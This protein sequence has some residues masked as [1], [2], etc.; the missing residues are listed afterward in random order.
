[1]RERSDQGGQSQSW[2][3]ELVAEWWA[4]FNLGW[5]EIDYGRF[6]GQ[7]QPALDAGC[8][9]TGRPADRDLPEPWPETAEP[10]RVADGSELLLR[11]RAVNV[12]PLDQAIT[13]ERGRS[14]GTTERSSRRA[15]T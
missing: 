1:L 9:T 14:A 2:H 15:C 5:P 7:G 11:T 12:D 4:E 13:F 10:R 6:V 3:H 8:G